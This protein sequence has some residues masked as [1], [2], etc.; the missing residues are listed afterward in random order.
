MKWWHEAQFGMFVH[1]GLYALIAHHEWT[2]ETEGIPVEEYEALARRFKPK[3]NAARDWAKLARETGMKYMV[4]TTKHHEGFCLFDSQHTDY[5]AP[6]H[7]CGRDLVAEYVDAAR[8][9]GLRVGFY[10]SLMDW[11]HPDGARCAHNENARKRFV[12]YLHG[13][14]RELCTNYGK[15]DILWYDGPDPLDA[16]GFESRKMNRM[17]RSLQP[18]ILI[19]NRSLLP[20]DFA[21][22]EQKIGSEPRDDGG[23]WE[24][25][26]TMNGEN[27]GYSNIDPHWKT[28]GQILCEMVCCAR[29]S[30]NYLLNVGPRPDGSIAPKSR[31]ILNTIGG[32]LDRNREAIFGIDHSSQYGCRFGSFTRRGKTLYLNCYAWPGEACAI[33]GLR[34]KVKSARLLCTGEAVKFDQSRFRVQLSGLP[35]KAPDNPLVTIA[36]ECETV[37][38]TDMEFV[39]GKKPRGKA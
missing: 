6:K 19:N 20:E 9:E 27:W 4:M 12:Q 28:P 34:A 16:K 35:K 13:Q 18:D 8:A 21:T 32:W 17:A 14:V 3:P 31:R 36:I 5:S 10:Y 26:I 29:D 30:G 22:P 11:H 15:I 37:P 23:G 25:C 38:V 33:A 7:A 1:W 2:M 39:R 24:S